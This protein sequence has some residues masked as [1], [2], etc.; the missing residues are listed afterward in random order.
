MSFHGGLTGVAIAIWLFCRKRGLPI[1][2]VGDA[3]AVAAPIGLFFGRL[4]NFVNGE[5]Y[6]RVTDV[7]WAIVFPRGGPEPRH[8]SQLYEA[9]L[10]GLTLFLIL[11]F[12]QRS[13]RVRT[14]AGVLTGIFLLGYA[15]SR[16]VVETV[17]EPDAQLGFLIGGTT[18]GQLLSIPVIIGGLYLILRPRRPA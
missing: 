16:I 12:A 10:E 9:A 18:M 11:F 17:R 5:L 13:A 14:K 6:G 2:G 8:P 15:I 7:P 4:A 1:L 3:I